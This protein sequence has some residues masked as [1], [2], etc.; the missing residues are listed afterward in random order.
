MKR[1]ACRIWNR[2][3]RLNQGLFLFLL[4]NVLLV[5]LALRLVGG[6]PLEATALADTATFLRMRAGGQDSWIPMRLALNHLRERGEQSLYTQLFFEDKVKF[7]YPPSSLLVLNAGV[8]A[9]GNDEHSLVAVLNALSWLLVG[10]T[11]LAVLL[12]IQ[13]GQSH[14]AERSAL[15]R[16]GWNRAVTGGLLFGLAVTFYPVVKAYTLGQ[17]QVWINAFFAVALWSWLTG[18]KKWCGFLIGVICLI[19][20][21]Y[22]VLVLWGMFRR[23]W[24]FVRASLA[25]GLAGLGLSVA[26][27]GLGNHLDY[28]RVLS[29]MSRHGESFYPNQSVNGLL[30]RLFHNGNNLNWDGHAFPP[31]HPWVYFGT[32][33][34]SLLLLAGAWWWP[35]RAQEKGSALDFSL[36]ALA[37]TM[38]SPIAWEHHYGILL[39]I[40]AFLLPRLLQEKGNQVRALTCLAVSYLLTSHFLMVTQ[41]L[42]ETPWNFVQSYLLA[43][44]VL[45]LAIL[46]RLRNQAILN[47]NAGVDAGPEGRTEG[48]RSLARAA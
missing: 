11:A 37:G 8:A 1:A 41:R 16:S 48:S 28:L 12:V 19:K 35:V 47:P 14:A 27:Y 15:D 45:V 26:L 2:T 24:G 6:E 23:Q 10:M 36:M 39:P 38:A 17:I 5:H 46:F 9:K 42:A 4:V 29:F 25:T 18:R 31:Y 34:S 7:Q 33:V 21:Q 30:H 32:L 44:A 13:H 40:Y 20:P 22:G 43:G 3:S